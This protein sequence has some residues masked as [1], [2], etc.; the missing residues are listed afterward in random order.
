MLWSNNNVAILTLGS[1]LCEMQG[2][3]RLKMC[4]GVKHIVTNRGECKV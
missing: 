2:P 4:L 1:Q 3:L